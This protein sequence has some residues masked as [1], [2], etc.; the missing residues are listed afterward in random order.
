MTDRK[1]LTKFE[2]AQ[3]VLEQEGRCGCGCGQKLVFEA[4]QIRDEHLH[5]MATGG[6]N[7]L[8][9]R[10]L[11]CLDCAKG[12]DK[13]DARARAKVRSLTKATKKSQKPKSKLQSRG[14]DK[15]LRKKFDG[16]VERKS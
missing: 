6:G 2:F 5:Q 13:K 15:T 1:A 14:F 12:K 4:G 8:T 10:S 9:N 16:T 7:E 11:W 3:L